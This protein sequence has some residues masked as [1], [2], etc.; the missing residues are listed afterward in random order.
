[1]VADT[2]THLQDAVQLYIVTASS[3]KG[4]L[5]HFLASLGHTLTAIQAVTY[6][7]RPLLLALASMHAKGLIHRD[8]KPENLLMG[9]GNTVLMCDFDLAINSL[10]E[11]PCSQVCLWPLL[12][13]SDND[14][15]GNPCQA[16]VK[17]ENSC[18]PAGLPHP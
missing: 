14:A 17:C 2:S 10:E 15:V 4:D 7:I 8:I 3:L 6:V 9:E 16:S 11:V 12:F 13:V 18:L 1:M 5:A